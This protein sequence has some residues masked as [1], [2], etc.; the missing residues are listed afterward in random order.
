MKH[1]THLFLYKSIINKDAFDN[2]I[3][4]I[5]C[6]SKTLN[7]SLPFWNQSWLYFNIFFFSNF[8]SIKGEL[9]GNI[10]NY[11]KYAH[12]THTMYLIE[13]VRRL[14]L[15]WMSSHVVVPVS[16]GR[17]RSTP[18]SDLSRSWTPVTGRKWTGS[19][20][21]PRQCVLLFSERESLN[22]KRRFGKGFVFH[23]RHNVLFK[24]SYISREV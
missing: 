5:D 2:D 8:N 3:D 1:T 7:I 22:V 17:G 24:C 6:L 4:C 12:K 9:F 13:F 23:R 10:N 14:F 19:R 18:G 21:Y 16:L 11:N 20:V 15:L